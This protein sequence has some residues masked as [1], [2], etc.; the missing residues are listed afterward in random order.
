MNIFLVLA[1][2]EPRSFNGALFQ[3]AQKFLAGAGH[4]IKTSDLYSME[5]N[6]VYSRHNF[7]SA[8]DPHYFKP[9]AEE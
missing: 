5:F 8:K 3:Q 7:T 2:P 6:P 4:E 9:Q 1:H